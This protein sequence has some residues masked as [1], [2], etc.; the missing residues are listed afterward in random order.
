MS[1]KFVRTTEEHIKDLLQHIHPDIRKEVETLSSLPY[2]ASIRDT[3]GRA[4]ESWTIQSDD[5]VLGIFGIN[6][7]QLLSDKG[8]PWLLTTYKIKKYVKPL[9]PLTKVA[10]SYWL[11]QYNVLENYVPENYSA[12]IR[13]LKWAGFT[14]EPAISV[15]GNRRVHRVEMRK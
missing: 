13:W 6:R 12:A 11:K 15:M 2:E 9:L 10:L 14:I 5:G 7:L 8:V 1:I 3:I 4:V